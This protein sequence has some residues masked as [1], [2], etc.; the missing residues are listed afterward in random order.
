MGGIVQQINLY[1][2]EA[3]N[4]AQNTSSRLLLSA[5]IGAVLVVVILA[6]AGEFYLAD[7]QARRDAVATKLATQRSEFERVKASL[8]TPGIDPFLEAELAALRHRQRE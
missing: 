2:G 6:G 3:S 5:G 7:V 1:T 8:V 4:V